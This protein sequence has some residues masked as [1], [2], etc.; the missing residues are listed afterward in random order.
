MVA[1][2]FHTDPSGTAYELLIDELIEKTD[3]FMLV[4]R[5]YVEGDTRGL[6]KCYKDLSRI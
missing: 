2:A 6:P 4:D 3:R 5:K 1:V